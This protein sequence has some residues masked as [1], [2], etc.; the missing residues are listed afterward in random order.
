MHPCCLSSS[1]VKFICSDLHNCINTRILYFECLS[2][3]F[4]EKLNLSQVKLS[5]VLK[6]PSIKSWSFLS[7][8]V[9]LFCYILIASCILTALAEQHLFQEPHF[10]NSTRDNIFSGDLSTS[11][12]IC[13]AFPHSASWCCTVPH[14][15]AWCLIILHIASWFCT[16]PRDAAWIKSTFVEVIWKLLILPQFT[17]KLLLQK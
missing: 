6:L 4:F 11:P 10:L 14:D 16:V 8:L 1:W 3:K 15:S 9:S 12:S 7:C 5:L 2:S 17:F 13:L